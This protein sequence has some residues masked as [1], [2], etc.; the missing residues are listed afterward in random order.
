[1]VHARVIMSEE[2][3][4]EVGMRFLLDLKGGGGVFPLERGNFDPPGNYG[5]GT[6]ATRSRVS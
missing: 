6:R 3:H 5:M 2:N 1:M 4:L